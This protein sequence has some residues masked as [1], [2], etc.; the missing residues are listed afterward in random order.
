M[1]CP[2]LY[3]MSME[4]SKNN[5]NMPLPALIAAAGA[6][7]NG[8]MQFLTNSKQ[9]RLA[10][11][12]ADRQERRQDYLTANSAL[13]DRLAKAKAG[14]NPMADMG[15]PNVTAPT[16]T[17]PTLQSPQMDFTSVA[18]LLQQAPLVK[19]QAEKTKADADLVKAQEEETRSRIPQNQA[20][21]QEIIANTAN[22]L[23]QN[24]ILKF[25]S[26]TQKEQFDKS[27][28]NLFAD[29]E[30]K[31]SQKNIADWETEI[32]KYDWNIYD[33]TLQERKETYIE[34]LN[35]LRADTALKDSE[36]RY[37]I[38]RINE[39]VAN[40][41]FTYAQK[42]RLEKLLEPEF[43]KLTNDADLSKEQTSFVIAQASFVH[44]QEDWYE[45]QQMLKSMG[46]S[47]DMIE[48]VGRYTPF[49]RF[50]PSNLRKH[51][52]GGIR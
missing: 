18:S 28:A 49:G 22:L 34:M 47:K 6:V 32:K 44:T 45:F 8:A 4:K 30:L 11:E 2:T 16:N 41:A 31:L 38:Q 37:N 3:I 21:T 13:F 40:V 25:Q 26:S 35:N 39:S 51:S 7:A 50:T 15:Y 48:K 1:L 43:N 5:K 9:T 52:K 12:M 19:A 46:V 27:M 20:K 23:E 42:R 33:Q 36:R 14:Y 24:G 10:R 17:A 29:T